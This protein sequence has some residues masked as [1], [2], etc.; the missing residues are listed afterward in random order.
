MSSES[1]IKAALFTPTS[2]GWGLPALFWGLSGVGKSDLIESVGK[3]WRMHVEVLSPSERGEG[4]FGVTP[5]PRQVGSAYVMSY[6]APDWIESFEDFDERGI[7]FL[8]ELTT[9]P[10]IIQA[11][12]LGLIQAKRIGGAT[13][14]KGVRILA[15]ANP[16]ELAAGG[17]DLAPPAANRLGHLHWSPPTEEEWADFEL[18]GAQ[19]EPTEVLDPAAEE[20]RVLKVWGRERAKAVGLFTA[21]H[22]RK[23]GMLH[24]QP[25]AGS[26]QATRAWASHRSWSN[27]ILAWTSSAVHSLTAAERI[28]FVEGFVGEGATRELLAFAHTMDLPDPVDLLEGRVT[29]EHDPRRLDRSQ[30]V[31]SSCVALVTGAPKDNAEVRVPALWTLLDR[32]PAD[33]VTALAVRPLSK[34]GLTRTREA[35]PVLARL[36]PVLVAAG[37]A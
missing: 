27:A 3:K 26:P 9:A 24:K 22:L 8:D 2:R 14:P 12:M 37:L 6:P 31:I 21:F 17:W 1:I 19:L 33:D 16:P 13:L 15:A 18:G 34:A 36:R 10:P 29:W 5:V 30:A 11:A 25:E 4:A 7:V 35:V 28:A 23:R 32:C 20:A